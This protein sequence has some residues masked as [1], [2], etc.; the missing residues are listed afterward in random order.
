MKR[1]LL[2]IV[3]IGVPARAAE[4]TQA[5][6]LA[7]LKSFWEKTAQPDG[8][9]R[10]GIPADYKGMSDSAASDLAP[11]TYAVTLHK[12]LG[13]KLPHE[14]KTRAWFLS[15]QQPDGA[16]VNVGGTMDPKGPLARLYNTTQG[17][18]ALR[19]LGTQPKHDPIPVF[20]AILKDD[21]KSLPS[22]TTSFFPLAYQCAGK[23]FPL[24]EDRKIKSLMVQAEDGY[25]HNHVA[26][27][28]HL[29][30]YYRLINESTPKADGILKRVIAE[31]KPD[32]SWMLNPPARDRHGCFDAVIC[33]KQLGKNDP[34][35]QKAIQKAAQWVL[36]CRNA[37]GGFGHYPG[38]PSDADAVYFHVGVLF[39]AG[40]LKPAE[41]LSD[42]HL[43]SWGHMMPVP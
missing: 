1:C 24:D 27:T 36:T 13:W 26:A 33:L 34:E 41:A 31:Q 19:A 10:P 20:A 15:R 6:V 42:G 25:L 28:F 9:F 2:V 39:M 38:S 32:G 3:L 17:L 4:P 11:A 5:E 22:Y 8:S 35:A 21:Y 12:T 7:G 37:D 43:L 40:Y 29:V 14:E 18:V 16:F 23:P 30:H